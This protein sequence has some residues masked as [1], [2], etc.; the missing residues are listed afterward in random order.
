[1]KSK[2]SIPRIVP[3]VYFLIAIIVMILL[4][5]FAPV[6]RWLHYPWRYAGILPVVI[7]FIP[8][9]GSGDLFRRLGTAPRPGVKA[10]VLVI[11]GAFRRTKNPMYLGL[12][13][14]LTG[15]SIF[16][17][18]FSP[19]IIIPVIIWILHYKFILQE[20]KW[21]ENWFGKSCLEYKRKTPGWL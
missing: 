10:N 6:G 4:N 15:L 1:M 13:V 11:Q 3:P 19:L 2:N 8:S 20:E 12:V 16:L 18:S 7:G 14:M 9:L 17:G 21:M 5:S